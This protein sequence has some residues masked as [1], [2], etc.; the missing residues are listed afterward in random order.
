MR[1]A[2]AAETAAPA[3]PPQDGGF[4][5]DDAELLRRAFAARNGEK[6]RRLYAGDISMHGSDRNVAD[7]ALCTSLAFWCGPDEARIDRLFRGSGLMRDKWDR[8]DYRQRTIRKA[9]ESCSE[10]YRPAALATARARRAPRSSQENSMNDGPSPD[11]E[12]ADGHDAA[13]RAV[14]IIDTDEYRAVD[15]TVAALR[16]DDGI[17]TR[18][19]MLVRVLR[20][21]YPDDGVV[22]QPG[23]PVIAALPAANLR[24][25]ITKCAALAKYDRKGELQPA[26]PPAWLVGAVLERGLWPGLRPLAGISDVPVLRPDG[27][28]W[29]TAGYDRATGVLYE[30]GPGMALVIPADPSQDDAWA[31]V[32]VLMEIV[33]DFRFESDEH[34]AA[35]LAALLTPLARFAFEG[36][37]PLFLIDAN[38]RGAGKG[39]LAQTIGRVSLGRDMPVSSYAHDS[40]EMRKKI[41]AIAI[42][43]D[44]VV[45]LDNLE[46][47]FGHDTL[48]RALTC[49]RWKDRIL[50]RSEQVDLPLQTVWYATGNNVQVGADTARRLVHIRLDVLEEKPE[51][52]SGFRHPDLL[53]W[54]ASERPRLLGAALTILS[55]FIRAGRPPQGLTPMGSFEGWSSSV[56]EAV[57]WAGLADPCR[58]RAALMAR[59][60]TTRDALAEL[61]TAWERYVPESEGL[62]VADALAA[63]YP[64]ERQRWP[65]DE[66]SVAMRAA[67]E[68]LV[69]CPP[70]KPP[71]ARQ[72]GAKLKSFRRRVV[73]DVYLESN[74]DEYNRAGSVWRLHRA[75]AAPATPGSAS[76]RVCE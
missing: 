75:E 32:D 54:I 4:E 39:L 68:S 40:D 18:G 31:A 41:T 15:E 63:L 65:M 72:V 2:V 11:G 66:P 69:G 35:W 67:L 49:T 7:L 5:G 36:P 61:V 21:E 23:S 47:N 53:A 20:E 27:T 8:D 58:S 46:G 19:T 43:A 52:R 33:E 42:A 55:A 12:A 76:L 51:E 14:I 45:L 64:P 50:G 26:H 29:Q 24:E 44:R 10:F 30:P 62:V 60:D 73:A 34:K 25:R 13:D 57:V 9:V 56:R 3:P 1:R 17:F 74:P 37:A 70:G 16:V 59:A 28:V 48:D 6:T 38:I 22:R 71:G